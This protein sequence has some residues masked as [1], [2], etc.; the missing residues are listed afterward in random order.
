MLVKNAVGKKTASAI[1]GEKL[2]SENFASSHTKTA[3]KS[4]NCTWQTRVSG[5]PVC[6]CFFFTIFYNSIIWDYF[7][8]TFF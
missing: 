7:I 6:A 2:K 5:K 4:F 8:L 3:T 1:G